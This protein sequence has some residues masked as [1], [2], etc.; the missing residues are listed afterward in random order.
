ML[1]GPKLTRTRERRCA[2]ELQRTMSHTQVRADEVTTN[3][4]ENNYGLFSLSADVGTANG[5]NLLLYAKAGIAILGMYLQY[6]LWKAN[7]TTKRIVKGGKEK[8]SLLQ[9]ICDRGESSSTTL[10]TATPALAPIVVRP[11]P[12]PCMT[13]TPGA[14]QEVLSGLLPVIRQQAMQLQSQIMR[15]NTWVL[16]D[17]QDV[18]SDA[19]ICMPVTSTPRKQPQSA[20]KVSRTP[21][22]SAAAYQLGNT[23]SRTITEVKQR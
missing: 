3:H 19:S 14:T 20:G 7:R 17:V 6:K 5:S 12:C 18:T 15:E 8:P 1:K 10:P 21:Y 4:E 9:R 2:G 22:T 23:S 13:R 11:P 16:T